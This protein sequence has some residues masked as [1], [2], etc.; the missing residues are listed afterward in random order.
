[1]SKNGTLVT[2]M[3][4]GI[5][6]MVVG[7]TFTSH[8]LG[9]TTSVALWAQLLV[10]AALLYAGFVARYAGKYDLATF[11]AI[12]AFAVT[13][14]VGVNAL[15]AGIFWETETNLSPIGIVVV[16]SVVVSLVTWMFFAIDLVHEAKP[17]RTPRTA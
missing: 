3:I 10:G 13:L 12:A 6:L 4:M 7:L 16:V 5:V 14:S 11:A 8:H 9:W 15:Q 2:L 1:M 17:R